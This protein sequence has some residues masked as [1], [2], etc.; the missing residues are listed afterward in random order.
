MNFA[1]PLFQRESG[2]HDSMNKMQH[3]LDAIK[4]TLAAATASGF[5]LTDAETL[6]K[7]LTWVVT[8]AYALWKWRQDVIQK[9]KEQDEP[10][11]A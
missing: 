4:V 5:S 11:E 10:E 3:K 1:N 7:C 9:R 2:D 6:L 8:I